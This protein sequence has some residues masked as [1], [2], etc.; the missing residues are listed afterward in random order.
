MAVLGLGGS[1][2]CPG[3]T[4]RLR[5]QVLETPVFHELLCGR[6]RT[7]TRV[8]A[9]QNGPF[10]APFLAPLSQI[11]FLWV[12]FFRPFAEKMRH[13]KFFS[14]TSKVRVLGGG[15]KVYVEKFMCFFCPFIAP[16]SSQPPTPTPSPPST[17]THPLCMEM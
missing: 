2:A 12:P 14:G 9:A 1:S 4:R 16:S 10:G 17:R 5:N 8:V 13:I 3:V 11:K 6:K 7:I 15:Q